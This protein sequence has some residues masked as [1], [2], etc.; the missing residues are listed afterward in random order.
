MARTAILPAFGNGPKR[1]C[2]YVFNSSLALFSISKAIAQH[3][4]RALVDAV[5]DHLRGCAF[6]K[7]LCPGNKPLFRC[8]EARQ[9]SIN[10]DKND[11]FDKRNKE[12][13]APK[14]QSFAQPGTRV[15]LRTINNNPAM[16]CATKTNLRSE[17][18][19]VCCSTPRAMPVKANQASPKIP[20]K[21]LIANSIPLASVRSCPLPST[22]RPPHGALRWPPGCR[23]RARPAAAPRGFPPACSRSSARP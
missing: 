11:A 10:T 9:E 3:Q 12:N 22:H 16:G 14:E 23:S 15:K 13:N 2:R 20:I 21:I 5:L 17:K 8:I 7:S 18:S 19:V 1:G 4:Q 6:W